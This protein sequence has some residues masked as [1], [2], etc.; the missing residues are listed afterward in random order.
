MGLR[1]HPKHGVN[2]SIPLCW[3]CGE[4]KNEILLF[5]AG[6]RDKQGN[7]EAPR[8]CLM[9]YEPCNKCRAA[10]E[11]GI[12]LIEARGEGF[13]QAT[14]RWAVIKREAFERLPITPPSLRAAI[15]E[16]GAAFLEPQVYGWIL[17]EEDGD[18]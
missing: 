16:K 3:W 4:G 8:H 15:L 11:L 12:L 17:G 13:E 14:G 2:P 7:T 10:Q 5:G 1:L 18:G 9:D 6:Y